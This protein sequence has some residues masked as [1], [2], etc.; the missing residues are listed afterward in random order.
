MAYLI[1]ISSRAERDLEQLYETINAGLS[2]TAFRWYLKLKRAILSLEN[3]PLRCPKTRED[4]K[5]RHLLYGSKPHVYRIIYQVSQAKKTVLVLHIR[6]GAMDEFAP[7]T[8][9]KCDST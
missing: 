1:K 6:H 9:K 4:I 2:D 7:D 5:L 8:I 3:S